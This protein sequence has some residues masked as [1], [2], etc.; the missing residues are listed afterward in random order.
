MVLLDTTFLSDL[1]RGR[2]EAQAA[3]KALEGEGAKLTSTTVN[4]AELYSGAYGLPD[5][6]SRIRTV[7]SLA[8]SIVLFPFD[9]RAARLYGRL[10]AG[11][12]S[13]GRPVPAK[14]LL[15]AAIGLAHGEAEVLTRNAK[16]F[17]NI[18]GIS[19]RAY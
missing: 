16:D 12:R 14:D 10:E 7:E 4:L 2:K 6:A 5:P 19:V 1:I 8:E 9:D 13:K 15:I 17:Q 18:P 3:L 11:L